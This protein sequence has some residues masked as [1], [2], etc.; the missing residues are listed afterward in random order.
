MINFSK[1]MVGSRLF[2]IFQGNPGMCGCSGREISGRSDGYGA[3]R[4]QRFSRCSFRIKCGQSISP[5]PDSFT[6][7]AVEKAVK[8]LSLT[9][10]IFFDWSALKMNTNFPI[11]FPTNLTRYPISFH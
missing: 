8:C 2:E 10:N 4:V 7:R 3:K 6:K 11:F 1:I 9:A 5:L